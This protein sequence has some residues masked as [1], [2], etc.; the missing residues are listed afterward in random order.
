MHDGVIPFVMTI[1]GT[2]IRRTFDINV[3][4]V[5]CSNTVEEIPHILER[6][7]VWPLLAANSYGKWPSR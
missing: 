7:N 6:S 5:D 1:K 3:L 4:P 2:G